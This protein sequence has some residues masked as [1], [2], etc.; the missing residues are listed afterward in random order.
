MAR[1]TSVLLA[2]NRLQSQ[3]S[4]DSSCDVFVPVVQLLLFLLGKPHY[5]LV[6]CVYRLQYSR[7]LYSVTCIQFPQEGA[8]K[9]A[10]DRSHSPTRCCSNASLHHPSSST[11][12]LAFHPHISMEYGLFKPILVLLDS[13]HRYYTLYYLFHTYTSLS[14]I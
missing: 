4:N 2:L 13:H 12:F 14:T 8:F 3:L 9:Q 6:F 5:V 11:L 10:Y 1:I 7:T